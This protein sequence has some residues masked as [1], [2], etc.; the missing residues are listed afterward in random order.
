VGTAICTVE[1]IIRGA[2]PPFAALHDFE[3]DELAGSPLAGLMAPHC[4]GELSLHILIACSRG[5]H[6][7]PSIH[8][9][10]GG[11]EFPVEVSFHLDAGG[12]RCGV[13]SEA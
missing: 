8:R 11:G 13:R 3:P 9:K 5:S 10:R 2:D 1:G 6:T 4:R 12:I 7:F